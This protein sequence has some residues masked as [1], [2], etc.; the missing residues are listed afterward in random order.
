MR[1]DTKTMRWNRTERPWFVDEKL[2][3]SDIRADAV[4][5]A[6]SNGIVLG[7]TFNVNRLASGG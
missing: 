2:L 4:T 5:G 3:R 7:L 6:V 1:L